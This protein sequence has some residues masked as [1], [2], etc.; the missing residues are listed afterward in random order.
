[1]DD[2][3]FYLEKKPSQMAKA[4]GRK[5]IQA[6]PILMKLLT[7]IGTCAMFLVGAGIILHGVPVLS[8]L[9]HSIEHAVEAIPVVKLITPVIIDG[10]A[11]VLI[12][13]LVMAGVSLVEK[14]RGL[15]TK[16]AQ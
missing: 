5:I 13:A 12:G 2:V 16:T 4:V 11:G 10:V 1:M 9:K 3:G 14:V 15:F 6:A 7:I 8:D